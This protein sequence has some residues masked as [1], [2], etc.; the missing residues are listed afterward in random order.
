MA[1]I[2]GKDLYL[3]NDDQ[4]YFG[5]NQEGALWYDNGE[6]QLNHTIS[7]TAATESYHLIQ[8]QQ[9]DDAMSTISGGGTNDHGQ[10]L[11]LG[12][13]DH[14]QYV[15]TSGTRGFTNTVSGIDPVEDYHLATKRYVDSV[16]TYPRYYIE[17]DLHISVHDWGQYVVHY[18]P[19]EVA[20]TLELGIGG[21]L[22]LTGVTNYG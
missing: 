22:I 1:R 10:L 14:L 11:G 20:G 8:K 17:P 9:L 7:G 2:K 16:G 19:L 5:D 15:P 12:D 21:M 13:D 6:L 4:I 3:N 18:T